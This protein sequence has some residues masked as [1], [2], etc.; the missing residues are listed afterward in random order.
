MSEVTYEGGAMTDKEKKNIESEEK[1]GTETEPTKARGGTAGTGTATSPER[2][3]EST[4]SDP[5][6]TGGGG[7]GSGVT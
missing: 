3:N 6:T 4:T 7:S 5:P 2:L 1:S